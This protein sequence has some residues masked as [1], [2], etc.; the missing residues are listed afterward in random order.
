MS[1][2]TL[3]WALLVVGCLTSIATASTNC[4]DS[5]TAGRAALL[6][7]SLSGLREAYIDFNEAMDSPTCASNSNLIFLHALTRAAMLVIDNSSDVNSVINIANAFGVTVV[8]DYFTELKLNIP[9]PGGC[10][11]I[12]SGAPDANEIYLRIQNFFIPEINSIIAELGTINDSASSR[13]QISFLPGETGLDKTIKVDYSEV[14]ILKGLLLGLKS[15]LEF[16]QAYYLVDPNDPNVQDA[17]SQLFCGTGTL[18]NATINNWLD[19]YP[20]LLTVLPGGNSVLAQSKKDIIDAINYYF[21]VIKYLESVVGP[22]EDHLIYID[23]TDR[24]AVDLVGTRLTTLQNSLKKDTAGSYPW[25]TIKTYKVRN[26]SKVIGNLVLIYDVTG[27]SGDGGTLTFSSSVVP[28]SWE[29][30]HFDGTGDG[31]G[32]DLD[33]PS[34]E[35]WGWFDGTLS[36]DGKKITNGTFEYWGYWSGTLHD[37]QT[38]TGLSAQLSK[39]QTINK[40]LNLNPVFGS[41]RYPNPV[42][43]RDLLPQFDNNNQLVPGTAGHGLGNDAT[44][45]GIL[46]DMTPQDWATGIVRQAFPKKTSSSPKATLSS[47]KA[48]PFQYLRINGSFQTNVP[49]TVQFLFGKT[50]LSVTPTVVTSN[51]I[52]VA[53]PPLLKGQVFVGGS[54]KVTVIQG[55]GTATTSISAGNLTVASLPKVKLP[56]GVVTKSFINVAKGIV[57]DAQT[58]ITGSAIDTEQTANTITATLA[59]FDAMTADVNTAVEGAKKKSAARSIDSSDSNYTMAISVSTVKQLDSYYAGLIAAG[60]L[61]TT[62]SDMILAY[63]SWNEAIQGS[64]YDAAAELKLIQAEQEY[65]QLVNQNAK[66]LTEGLNSMMAPTTATISSLTLEG[67]A[68]GNPAVATAAAGLALSSDVLTVGMVLGLV[69]DAGYYAATDDTVQ[70]QAYLQT[71]GDMAKDL[72]IGKA[73]G[74]VTKFTLGESASDLATSLRDLFNS[75]NDAVAPLQNVDQPTIQADTH[76]PTGLTKGNYMMTYSTNVSAITCCCCSPQE[77]ITTP[78][79]STPLT[80]LGVIPLT[81]PKIFEKVLVQAFNAAVAGASGPGCSQSVSYSPFTGNAFTATYTVTCTSEGCTGGTT[82]FN[83]TLQKQ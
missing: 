35:R 40:R 45:G 63:K 64:H 55:T 75:S 43:P 53:V 65:Q 24:P 52:R 37:T 2:R 22:R 56:P 3:V 62:D 67:I 72:F 71:A 36:S 13:F 1:K 32:F 44:L 8:G 23:P 73:L 60:Q 20:L 76:F 54:A 38:V 4:N 18:P 81:S 29:V 28:T 41:K 19:S 26:G 69:L 25:E 77:C 5:Y 17:I 58:K 21:A 11:A 51:T 57:T 66:A 83:F 48:I 61:N 31:F 79:Y 14:L 6:E 33:S 74:A 49:T 80:T 7:G 39:T 59:F 82:T 42:N 47:N 78:G 10:Y 50:S 9:T 46:P 12:P 30:N 15:Q 27:L 70:Y 34:E 68:T 16:K